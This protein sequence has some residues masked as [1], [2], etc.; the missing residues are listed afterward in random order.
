MT[1]PT[2]RGTHRDIHLLDRDWYAGDPY[3]DYAWLREQ[4]PVYYSERAG[5]WNKEI[6]NRVLVVV[7]AQLLLIDQFKAGD[8]LHRCREIVHRAADFENEQSFRGEG[9]RISA[10]LKATRIPR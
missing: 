9:S 5:V 2:L 1:A 8:A 7:A 10:Q 3:G 4:A 6:G